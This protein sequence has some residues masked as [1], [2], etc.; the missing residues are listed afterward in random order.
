MKLTVFDSFTSS[1]R[2]KLVGCGKLWAERPTHCWFLGDLLTMRKCRVLPVFSSDLNLALTFSFMPPFLFCFFLYMK[3][4][5]SYFLRINKN[6]RFWSKTVTLLSDSSCSV[7]EAGLVLFRIQPALFTDCNTFHLAFLRCFAKMSFSLHI[8]FPLPSLQVPP[9][10]PPTPTWCCNS[11]PF[12]VMG[13]WVRY[14]GTL[15]M[16]QGLHCQ[17]ETSSQA[18]I[19]HPD[20]H[21][22]IGQ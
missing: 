15:L 21:R 20:F 4:S 11:N 13:I 12:T 10:L 1:V 5:P 17:E 9:Q 14:M 2:I 18:S 16:L 7:S 8:L 3:S 19:F 6:K 22:F